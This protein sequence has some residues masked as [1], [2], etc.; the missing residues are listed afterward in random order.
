MQSDTGAFEPISF[1]GRSIACWKIGT[2]PDLVLVHGTPFSSRVWRRIAPALAGRFT[3]YMFDLLGYGQSE[4][5]DDDVSLGIQN[6]LLAAAFAHWSLTHPYVIAHDFGGAT[7]LRGHLLNGLDYAGLILVN[8]VAMRPWG[9][10]FVAHVRDHEAAFSG[11]PDYIHAAVLR[12]YIGGAS[13]PGLSDAV[14]DDLSAPW[15]G[16]VGKSAF[17]RQIAQMNQR[18][19]DEVENLYPAIRCPVH[20]LLGRDDAWLPFETARRLAQ[21]IPD[22]RFTAVAGCGHLMQEDAPEAIVA[23]ALSF[24]AEDS[25]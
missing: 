11:I 17:Y 24:F 2:G 1:K 14:L 4:M 13:F 3:V 25:R 12:A 15:T 20:L 19:T 18:H 6:E 10:P 9:S 21:M 8:P 7:A 22:C 23:A 16:L 5:P